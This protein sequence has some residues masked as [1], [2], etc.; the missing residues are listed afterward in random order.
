MLFE[1]VVS[2]P[3]LFTNMDF[4]YRQKVLLTTP[5]MSLNPSNTPLLYFRMSPESDSPML[6][7]RSSMSK[8]TIESDNA[9]DLK[10]SV[11]L[12]SGTAM[13]VGTMIGRWSYLIDCLCI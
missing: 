9:T 8:S 4:A 3:V 13:I 7:E 10:K 11:G 2:A 1:L 6:S 12:L 5:S